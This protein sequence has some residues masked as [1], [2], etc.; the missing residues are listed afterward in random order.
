MASSEQVKTYLACWLQLGKNLLHHKQ[1]KIDLSEPIING[2][3]YSA[4]FESYWQQILEQNGRG[5]YLE[6]ANCT[7]E[8]LLSSSWNISACARC[9]MPVP[10][11]E[12]GLQD[13]GCPCIDLPLWPNTSLPLPRT[14][15]NSQARIGRIRENLVAK[16]Y[17]KQP[18]YSTQE[19][20]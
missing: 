9:R 14:P 5:Y 20:S 4:K 11:I 6:G 10:T 17:S 3:R 2:D 19:N 1:E 13:P 16:H 7:I 8:E 18:E 12:L 15:V